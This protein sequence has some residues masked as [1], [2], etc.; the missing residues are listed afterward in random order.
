MKLRITPLLT[1]AIVVAAAC[2]TPEETKAE[3]DAEVYAL[4][5]ARR[6][7]MFARPA[8][9]NIEPN[10]DSLRQRILAGEIGALPPL[11]LIQCL[12]IA[13]ENSRNY[14]AE[15]ESLY[16]AALNL[17][18]EK[19][20]FSTIWSLDG[21]AVVAGNGNG[22]TAETV[23][24][25]LGMSKL[26][27]SGAAIVGDIGQ[28]LLRAVNTG[29]G[30]DVVSSIGLTIT[31][32]LLRGAA[33]E[34]VREP[35]TQSERNL[36]YSV[37]DYESFRRDFVISI[38]TAYYGVLLTMDQLENEEA[39]FVQLQKLSEYNKAKFEAGRFSNLEY[40]EAKA[41]ELDS[42]ANLLSL[43]E[44][45]GRELDSFKITLGLPVE[46][47]IELNPSELADLKDVDGSDVI[48]LD[49]QGVV[50]LGLQRRLDLLN[51][52]DRLI[53]AE[54]RV[55]IAEDALRAGLDFS[56]SLNAASQEGQP[57]AFRRSEMA[58]TVG[59]GFDLPIDN[60]PERNAYRSS[61]IT[62]QSAK[63]STEQLTD[64][65]AADLADSLRSTRSAMER[66]DI[67]SQQVILNLRRVESEAM[68][69]QAGR[70]D[71]LGVLNAQD[72]YLGAQNQA[73]SALV[74]FALA[75]LGL[76]RDLELLEFEPDGIVVRPADLPRLPTAPVAPAEPEPQS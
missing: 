28:N 54:R 75:R 37:R 45:L 15:K 48:D 69:L 51:T 1:L 34:V 32:P 7:S 55:R 56:A 8:G 10:P 42:A 4:I 14:Q 35:L 58:W 46:V 26:L 31:Q 22:D 59:L 44:R 49:P 36:L 61:I 65:I 50:A 71:T 11:G 74:Q 24:A 19:W 66:Y 25:D 70:T 38:V 67:Q 72:A 41:S 5:D 13:A 20:N 60:L 2:A 3:A 23:G 63:R 9:F 53:D 76:Y 27:G 21:D 52:V 57:V 6:D 18:L 73:S 40:D 33:R 30:W 39:N 47:E 16:L 43:R 29:D 12:E 68:N 17:T 64:Q 62:F